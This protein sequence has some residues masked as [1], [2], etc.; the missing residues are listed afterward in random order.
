MPKEYKQKLKSIKNID[1]LCLKNTGKK[2][3]TN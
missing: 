3:K 2:E 1:K